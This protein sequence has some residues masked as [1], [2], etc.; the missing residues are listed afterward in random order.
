MQN[1]HIN[2]TNN[3]VRH[4]CTAHQEGDWIIYRCPECLSYERRINWQTGEM[5]VKGN[6]RFLHTGNNFEDQNKLHFP[7]SREIKGNPSLN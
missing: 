7:Q 6:N 2:A 5:R 3:S 1:I 4:E